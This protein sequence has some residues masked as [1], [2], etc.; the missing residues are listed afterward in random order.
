MFMIVK[1]MPILQ[2]FPDFESV[3]KLSNFYVQ[4]SVFRPVFYD[5]ETTGLSQYSTFLYL[6]GGI[7]FEDGQW[8]LYQWFA[9]SE[10]DEPELLNSFASFV[11]NYTCT[12]QYNGSRF[13]QPYLE[14]RYQVWELPSP[15]EGISSLDLYQEL[16]PCREL[17]KLERMKQPDLESFLQLSPRLFCDGRE[18]IR[19]YRKYQKTRDEDIR[20][21]LFGHNQEDLL[22][23]GNVFEMLSYRMIYDGF[24]EADQAEITEGL[25]FITLRLFAPVPKLFSNGNQNFY[26]SGEGCTVKILIP[27]KDGKLRQYYA[28]Y[29]HYD[30]LPSEDTAIPRALSAYIDRSLR[31]P[32][33]PDTCYTWFTCDHAFLTDQGRQMQYLKHTLPYLLGTLK[34]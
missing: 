1:K 23:L 16:K 32:A 7:V 27:L 25:L 6:I 5:I 22:G 2:G 17:L 31:V 15:F 19:C 11:K 29:K 4:G 10:N 20:Q 26:I 14:A 33:K 8:V 24:Y 13:D 18:G 28:D 30:Y 21:E 12:L 9:E 34:R 3:K